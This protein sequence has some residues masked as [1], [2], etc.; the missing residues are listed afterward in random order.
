[1][2]MTVKERR[3]PYDIRIKATECE[4]ELEYPTDVLDALELSMKETAHKCNLE[5]LE[6]VCYKLNHIF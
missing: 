3:L 6:Q 2:S 5:S 4:P 1:M